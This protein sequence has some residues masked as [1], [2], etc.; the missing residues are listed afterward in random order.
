LSDLVT[1]ERSLHVDKFNY[2]APEEPSTVKRGVKNQEKADSKVLDRRGDG[3]ILD[4]ST[5]EEK[6]SK[7]PHFGSSE[8][9][10]VEVGLE[11]SVAPA[12]ISSPQVVSVDVHP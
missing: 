3:N 11:K 7:M 4:N 10:F 5:D 1:T 9:D 8:G 2:I 12:I 6:V